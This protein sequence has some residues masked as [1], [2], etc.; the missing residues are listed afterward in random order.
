MTVITL[1]KALY[2]VEEAMEVLSLSRSRFY[3]EV[4][5]GRLHI[6]KSGRATRVTAEDIADFVALLKAEAEQQGAA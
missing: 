4:A 2:R 6:V 1:T 3:K 5:A